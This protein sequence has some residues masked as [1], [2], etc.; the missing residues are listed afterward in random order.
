[1]VGNRSQGLD[2]DIM[3]SLVAQK[4]MKEF[5]FAGDDS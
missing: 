1:M 3:A 2:L 4:W 5:I